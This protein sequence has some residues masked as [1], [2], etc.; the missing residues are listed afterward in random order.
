MNDR[1][2]HLD[3]F[4]QEGEWVPKFLVFFQPNDPISVSPNGPWMISGTD[5]YDLGVQTIIV[6]HMG[7]FKPEL[8]ALTRWYQ[9]IIGTR[10][11]ISCISIPS[12]TLPLPL[13]QKSSS[14]STLSFNCT[15]NNITSYIMQ[16]KLL[17]ITYY[18]VLPS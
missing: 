10:M 11:A 14:G 5:A 15:Y 7:T 12:S 2:A 18:R 8:I 1:L 17:Y 4:S 3:F 16:F 9:G 13:S 6:R